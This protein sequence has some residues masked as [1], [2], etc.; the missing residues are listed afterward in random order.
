VPHAAFACPTAAVVLA[1][2]HLRGAGLI[3]S[4]YGM[5]RCRPA[6]AALVE[7]WAAGPWAGRLQ[8]PRDFLM[9][10]E[11]AP[12]VCRP[13]GRPGEAPITACAPADLQRTFA[14]DDSIAYATSEAEMESM[15]R[16]LRPHRSGGGHAALVVRSVRMPESSCRWK[17]TVAEEM[18][19]AERG[20]CAGPASA[21]ENM[22]A[23]AD[24]QRDACDFL[25]GAGSVLALQAQPFTTSELH[26][27]V[28]DCTR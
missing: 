5:L 10:M 4:A 16:A 8:P 2:V 23:F 27:A 24:M 3:A 25:L 19:L 22:A 12:S 7:R 18:W 26:S 11:P 17:A 14:R 28:G 9:V 20:A 6:V 15:L 1:T 21:L 13:Q